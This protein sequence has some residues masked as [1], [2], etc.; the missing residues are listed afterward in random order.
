MD[1]IFDATD[2]MEHPFFRTDDT[3]NV[4]VEPFRNV[5][6]E[7]WMPMFGAKDNVQVLREF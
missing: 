4:W 5:G 1:V 3:A 2:L 6:T 7:P